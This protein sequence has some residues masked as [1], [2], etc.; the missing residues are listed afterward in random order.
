VQ[1]IQANTFLEDLQCVEMNVFERQMESVDEIY[2]ELIKINDLDKLMDR[3]LDFDL[4]NDD[5]KMKAVWQGMLKNRVEQLPDDLVFYYA[6]C[7]AWYDEDGSFVRKYCDVPLELEGYIQL[8]NKVIQGNP[9]AVVLKELFDCMK[10]N[11]PIMHY[12]GMLME[13]GCQ[14]SSLCRELIKVYNKDRA[15]YLKEIIWAS[16]N[17]YGPGGNLRSFLDDVDIGHN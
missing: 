15:L 6:L 2:K 1:Q 11:I 8:Y 9:N 17:A 14:N 4:D 16:E 12:K 5:D 10:S 7:A 13:L 3:I